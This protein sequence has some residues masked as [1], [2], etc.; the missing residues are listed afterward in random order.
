MKATFEGI[1]DKMPISAAEHAVLLTIDEDL[2]KQILEMAMQ[3]YAVRGGDL[4][5][6]SNRLFNT[7]D[8]ITAACM[9]LTQIKN[10]EFLKARLKNASERLGLP[11][12][13]QFTQR[14][15]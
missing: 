9:M 1:D 3:I 7:N 5:K 15:E 11:M 13:L 2:R 4:V 8:A 12:F 10:D 6:N 14:G